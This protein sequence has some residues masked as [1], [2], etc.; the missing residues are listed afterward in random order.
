MYGNWRWN[1]YSALI[2][3]LFVFLLG[4]INNPW[5]IALIRGAYAAIG[6]ALLAFPIR[7]IIGLLVGNEEEV[8]EENET[9]QEVEA[10]LA[11]SNVD[12]VTPDQED[13]NSIIREQLQNVAANEEAEVASKEDKVNQFEP[14]RPKKFVSTENMEPQ[15][16]TKAVRHLTGE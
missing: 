2:G 15:D 11:G 12:Y 14:L 6:F 5:N 10:N 7:F 13:L 9:D 16:L 4:M 3:I 8:E 1:V